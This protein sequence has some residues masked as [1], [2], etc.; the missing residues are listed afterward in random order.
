VLSELEPRIRQLLDRHLAMATEWFPH[1]FVPYG[2]AGSEIA[3]QWEPRHS[4]FPPAVRAALQLNLLTEDN[5]PYYHLALATVGTPDSAW[6]EWSRRWTA[7]EGRHA[8]VLRDFLT[9]TRAI[10]PVVLERERMAQ[11]SRGYYPTASGSPCDGLVY[12]TLQELATR[13]AHRN[14][15]IACGD[16]TA[17]RLMTRIALD[18][19]L[20]FAFYRDVACGALEIDPSAMVLAMRREVLGF[21]MPGFA[22]PGFRRA[23]ARI[24]AAHIYDLRIH[25]DQVLSPVIL[26]HFRLQS[27]TGLTDAAEHARDEVLGFLAAIDLRAGAHAAAAEHAA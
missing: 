7:E 4:A 26:G 9:V 25:H 1:Q 16:A 14:T 8:I 22:L 18:E 11:V 5:L 20:H 10:D 19:S 2:A 24:A 21:S 12:V 27:L 15:G 3:E 17:E 6:G 13:I 23:A